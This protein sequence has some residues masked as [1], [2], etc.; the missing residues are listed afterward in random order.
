[1]EFPVDQGLAITG[2]KVLHSIDLWIGE[3]F[4]KDSVCELFMCVD[5]Q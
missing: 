1:M 3:G 5:L 2:E 4:V